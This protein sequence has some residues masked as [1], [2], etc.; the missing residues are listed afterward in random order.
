MSRLLCL[1]A[2]VTKDGEPVPNCF[3]VIDLKH[4][5]GDPGEASFYGIGFKLQQITYER[6]KEVVTY[7]RP[8]AC[9]LTKL[10]RADK[11]SARTHE[12]LVKHAL[13]AHA[14]VL[15][16]GVRNALKNHAADGFV[17]SI[18]T[19]D[20]RQLDAIYAATA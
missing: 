6:L 19:A 3:V 16:E 2:T 15:R 5:A 17:V 4:Y 8:S 7:L 20:Q 10:V 18:A 11:Y 1:S 12:Y 14:Q 9:V 13:T